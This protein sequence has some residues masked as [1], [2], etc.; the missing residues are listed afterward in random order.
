MGA[1]DNEPI[2]KVVQELHVDL[3]HVSSVKK[4]EIVNPFDPTF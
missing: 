3:S 4:L 1:C 2:H